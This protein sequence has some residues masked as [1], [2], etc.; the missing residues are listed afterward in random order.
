M[1][2]CLQKKGTSSDALN[3]TVHAKTVMTDMTGLVMMIQKFSI[4]CKNPEIYISSDCL[5]RNF[6]QLFPQLTVMTATSDPRTYAY[7]YDASAQE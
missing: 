7:M 4:M 6:P 3:A 1:L 2:R 5:F